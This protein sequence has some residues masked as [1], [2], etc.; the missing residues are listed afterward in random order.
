MNITINLSNPKICN[1]CPI[2]AE[3]CY[4]NLGYW[5]GFY[6]ETGHY[7]NLDGVKSDEQGDY[8]RPQ[9]C[10]DDNGE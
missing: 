8:I 6:E 3:E 4:C 7:K 2:V 5:N 1:G 9:K 10:I